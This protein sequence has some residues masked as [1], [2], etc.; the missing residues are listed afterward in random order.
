MKHQTSV[1]FLVGLFL[2]T[3][4]YSQNPA[5]WIPPQQVNWQWQLTSP[6]DVTIDAQVYDIDLFNNDASVVKAL[7]DKGRKVICYVSVGT[8][9]G[10]RPDAAKFPESVKGQILPDFPDE[11]WLDIRQLDILKPVIDARFDLCTVGRLF[12][13]DKYIFGYL[14][15]C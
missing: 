14:L 3:T 7:H 9:E 12:K 11:R 5:I 8:Y 1:W 10:W 2:A 15:F 13:L 4:L 6:V